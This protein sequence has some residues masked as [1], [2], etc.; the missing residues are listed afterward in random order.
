[1]PTAAKDTLVVTKHELETLADLEQRY[2]RDKRDL[3]AL[4]KEVQLARLT[5]AEKV[6]G[7]TSAEELK[8]L[9]PEQVQKRYA[10]RL[11]NEDWRLASNAPAFV[12]RKTNEGRYPAWARLFIAELGETAAAR[13][14][15]DTPVSYSYC[16]EVAGS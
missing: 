10:K 4:E 14:K 12:F 11:T 5:L 1:M 16:V 7:V 9:S 3:A 2:T 6:L 8:E 15:A 13:I